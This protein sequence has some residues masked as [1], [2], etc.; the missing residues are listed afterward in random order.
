MSQFWAILMP[1]LVGLAAGILGSLVAPWVNWGI[2][3]RREKLR[4]R[5]AIIDRCRE[6]IR[7]T[8]F[9]PKAFAGTPEYNFLRPFLSDSER[10]CF[11]KAN[12]ILVGPIGHDPRIGYQGALNRAVDKLE[13]Q[14][15]LL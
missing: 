14:W 12:N 5:R 6:A 3:R 13:S 11:E 7:N 10:D 1:A 15:D 8:E 4:H 9:S 2:E